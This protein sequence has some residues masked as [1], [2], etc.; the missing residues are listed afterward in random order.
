MV[1][2]ANSLSDSDLVNVLLKDLPTFENAAK[3]DEDADGDAARFIGDG[4]ISL[5]DV[6]S[7]ASNPYASAADR[8]VATR[9]LLSDDSFSKLDAGNNADGEI[10]YDDLL[11]LATSG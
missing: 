10:S 1:D 11:S 2:D 7:V 5:A 3:A 4:T 8:D 9:L 6:F